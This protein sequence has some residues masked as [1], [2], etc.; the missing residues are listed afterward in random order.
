MK[1]RLAVARNVRGCWGAN[2]LQAGPM[3]DCLDCA[4]EEFFLSSFAAGDPAMLVDKPANLVTGHCQP[5]FIDNEKC[6]AEFKKFC[7]HRR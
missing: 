4:Y 1:W 5:E 7:V 2:R 3:Q 6:A